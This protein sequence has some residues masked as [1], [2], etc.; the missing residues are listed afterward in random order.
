[1]IQNNRTSAV[2][3]GREL[4]T[5]YIISATYPFC[6]FHWSVFLFKAFCCT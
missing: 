1:M 6:S 4:Q 5:R 2:S 3:P